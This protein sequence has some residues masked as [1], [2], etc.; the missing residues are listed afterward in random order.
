[1]SF[2]QALFLLLV[3]ITSLKAQ[4][5][6]GDYTPSAG[7]L[8]GGNYSW[9]QLKDYPDNASSVG[10]LGFAGGVFGNLPITNKLFVQPQLMY[11]VMGGSIND[12]LNEDNDRRQKLYYA[13]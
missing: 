4:P 3:S 7:F 13:S 8:L 10:R 5:K 9:L 1:M 6:A 11:S 2:K 12:D